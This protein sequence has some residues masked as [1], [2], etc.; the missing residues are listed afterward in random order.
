MLDTFLDYKDVLWGFLIAL[1]VVLALTPA[2]GR[3]ARI[4]GVVDEPGEKRRLHRVPV[5]R[6]GGVAIFLGIIIPSLAFL[7]LDGPYRGILLGA[8]VAMAVGLADD[9]GGLAWWVKLGG[10][11]AAAGVAVSFGVK[12]ESFTFPL[13]GVHALPEWLGVAL[14]LLWIVALMNMVNFLDGMDGLAAGVCGIAGATFSVIALSLAKPEAA[15]L[16]AI[17]AGAC[18]GFLRHNFYPA[19]IFMGDSGAMLLGFTLA[20]V[21]IQGLLKTAATVALF[22][23]LL[24][25]LVP[26]ID[27]SFVV[28]KR[29]KY[30]QPIFRAD[31]WHLHHRFARIGFSQRRAVLYLWTWC[32]ILAGAALATRFIPFRAHGEWNVW[33]TVAVSAIAL[34]AVAAS[35]YLVL[36]LEIL[37]LRRFR[38]WA[39]WRREAEE[40]RA[41]RTA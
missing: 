8:A 13:V 22:F 34:V 40:R 16:S 33:P 23:P 29:L 11:F 18:F 12:L 28:A 6:L 38:E 21:S 17:V 26:I 3:V 27:T 5:P 2:V 9:L 37:K 10:Q 30:G 35:V 14:S 1:A 25:L 32:A 20:A 39:A 36:L 19:R 15:V 31:D 24:V 4:L 41:R 7:P